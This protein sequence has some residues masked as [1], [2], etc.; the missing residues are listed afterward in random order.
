MHNLRIKLILAFLSAVIVPSFFTALLSIKETR[1]FAENP[2][3]LAFFNEVKQIDNGIS[4]MFK[5][6]A[7]NTNL[8][9]KNSLLEE[10]YQDIT[11]YMDKS[12]STISPLAVESKQ[13]DLY[14]LF[15]DIAS[16]FS[17]LNYIYYG[18]TIGGYV[19]WP[20]STLR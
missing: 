4:L 19:Q 20:A 16:S 14:R 9:S 3:N 13:A 12:A 15:L 1:E 7:D 6:I 17:E 5:L 10:S 18:T 2:F 11:R 8:L